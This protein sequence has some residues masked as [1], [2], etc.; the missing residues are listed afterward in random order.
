V[1]HQRSRRFPDSRLSD[2]FRYLIFYNVIE[3]EIFLFVY[4]DH[5]LTDPQWQ[6]LSSWY[7]GIGRS[8]LP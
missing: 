3:L 5:N 2:F 7:K 1:F 4:F 8:S 6:S